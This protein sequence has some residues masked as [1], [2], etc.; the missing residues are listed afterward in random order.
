MKVHTLSALKI[1]LSLLIGAQISPL[2]AD[3]TV[4][5]EEI[6]NIPKEFGMIQKI[7]SGSSGKTLYLLSD[8]H[9]HQETQR[10]EISI[11]QHLHRQTGLKWIFTEGAQGPLSTALFRALSYDS[12]FQEKLLDEFLAQGE[13]TSAECL[14]VSDPQIWHVQGVEK[15]QTFWAQIKAFQKAYGASRDHMIQILEQAQSQLRKLFTGKA[16]R[17]FQKFNTLKEKFKRGKIALTPYCQKLMA[18]SSGLNSKEAACPQLTIIRKIS[19][20]EYSNFKKNFEHELQEKINSASNNDQKFWLELM[21]KHRLGKISLQNYLEQIKNRLTPPEKERFEKYRDLLR[22]EA[23]L[24]TQKTAQEIQTLQKKIERDFINREGLQSLTQKI[25]GFDL[26]KRFSTLEL[27]HSQWEYLKKKKLKKILKSFSQWKGHPLLSSTQGRKLIKKFQRARHFYETAGRRDRI[28]S[29]NI[30][31]AMK[32]KNVQQAAALIGGF[33]SKTMARILS[34]KGITVIVIIPKIHGSVKADVYFNRM[35]GHETLLDKILNTRNENFLQQELKTQ[36]G[37]SSLLQHVMPPLQLA[38]AHA[39]LRRTLEAKALLLSLLNDLYLQGDEASFAHEIERFKNEIRETY[40]RNLEDELSKSEFPADE[41]ARILAESLAW[42]EKFFSSLHVTNVKRNGKTLQIHAAFVGLPFEV[43]INSPSPAQVA[44]ASAQSGTL[45]EGVTWTLSIPEPA[46]TRPAQ[47]WWESQPEA[48]RK[49]TVGGL[50]RQQAAR[51]GGRTMMKFKDGDEEKE[52]SWTAIYEETKHLALGLLNEYGPD[53]SVALLSKNRPQG[54]CLDFACVSVG[55]PYT[56][57]STE[58][59]ESDLLAILQDARPKVIAVFDQELLD[60]LWNVLGSLDFKPAIILLNSKLK[61]PASSLKIATLENIKAEGRN[62]RAHIDFDA[63][64]DVVPPDK[65]ITYLYTSGSEGLPKGIGFTQR[66][67]ISKRVARA[68]AIPSITEKD[69]FLTYLPLY[70]TFGRWFEL[71][72]TLY[73]GATYVF[74]N[75]IKTPQLIEQMKRVQP[76]LF[77]SVPIVWE[78]ILAET[79]K[80]FPPGTDTALIRQKLMES[81]GGQIKFALSG[82][83]ILGDEVFHAFREAG[84]PVCSG[85]G[86]T[87]ATGGISMTPLDANFVP[88]TVGKLLPGIDAR[89]DPSPLGPE[90]QNKG[91]GELILSGPYISPGYTSKKANQS[92]YT[93]Q[94]ELRSGDIAEFD[95][96]GNLKIVGRLK[97]I[98]KLST[99]R[100]VAPAALETM[101]T[102]SSV[103]KHVCVIGDAR[104][105]LSALIEVDDEAIKRLFER[106][107]VPVT[108][109]NI[110]GLLAYLIRDMNTSFPRHERIQHFRIITHFDPELFTPKGTLKRGRVQERYAVQIGQ[111]YSE[112]ITVDS[113]A[114]Q[115]EVSHRTFQPELSLTQALPKISSQHQATLRQITQMLFDMRQRG[116]IK[117]DQNPGTFEIPADQVEQ[118]RTLISQVEEIV[119]FYPEDYLALRCELTLWYAYVNSEDLGHRAQMARRR[120]RSRLH[121][122]LAG[123]YYHGIGG[124]SDSRT[125]LLINFVDIKTGTGKRRKMSQ[126]SKN[127]IRHALNENLLVPEILWLLGTDLTQIRRQDIVKIDVELKIRNLFQDTYKVTVHLSS[128]QTLLFELAHGRKNL[129]EKFHPYQEHLRLK[130]EARMELSAA[131]IM[132]ERNWLSTPPAISHVRQTQVPHPFQLYGG[133]WYK[134]DLWTQALS[135]GRTLQQYLRMKRDQKRVDQKWSIVFP[136]IIR[137][138]VIH[139]EAAS[140]QWY[141]ASLSLDRIMSTRFALSKTGPLRLTPKGIRMVRQTQRRPFMGWIDFISFIS[142]ELAKDLNRIG[143]DDLR[144]TL[145]PETFFNAILKYYGEEEGYFI[146]GEILSENRESQTVPIKHQEILNRLRVFLTQAGKFQ[147]PVPPSPASEELLSIAA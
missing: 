95:A 44:Q 137:E 5:K 67:I 34:E 51:F 8:I 121:D 37:K 104:P 21:L 143:L 49:L 9:A 147:E 43:Q 27:S 130:Q 76:T 144:E 139:L 72:G 133:Y 111:M 135:Q 50:L 83:G 119:R 61:M 100:T 14:A 75:N 32:K 55:I 17:G 113:L 73:W 41:R 40:Q 74:V 116:T 15:G 54:A 65:I 106:E 64:C 38:R 129:Y 25:K 108:L 99:G 89:L 102:S 79:L 48:I 124:S 13:L 91:R 146:L 128:G 7:Y 29:K 81:T 42:I 60:K 52:L 127:N 62:N 46:S 103:I 68:Q 112:G 77:I 30:F 47:Q 12:D 80:Q 92:G 98:I 141:P 1:T 134:G 122:M 88:G 26:L 24:D 115:E 33:H 105:R 58:L 118:A 28:L 39:V 35:M 82:G 114:P 31:R 45:R 142:N 140:Y 18:I 110:Y 107:D 69:T 85:F 138:M 109:D 131:H 87:E 93:P 71:Y 97:D 36:L 16:S 125:P 22:L 66:N 94:G 70:H 78:R 4:Q 86:M 84:V 96:D 145:I 101:L 63:I 132:A 23:S 3:R 126:G 90:E 57:V 10:Q 2:L 19:R 11:L 117:T 123:A 59:S 56:P 53:V 6:C 120:L 136:K 20:P